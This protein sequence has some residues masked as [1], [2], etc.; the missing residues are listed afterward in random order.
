MKKTFTFIL[1]SVMLVA[2]ASLKGSA[3]YENDYISKVIHIDEHF[4]I[5]TIITESITARAT[6]T[7]QTLNIYRSTILMMNCNEKLLSH[8]PLNYL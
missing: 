8:K 5:V 2:C 7:N 1:T 4:Y 6:K 3:V